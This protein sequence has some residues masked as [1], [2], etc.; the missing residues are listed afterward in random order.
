MT[1][2]LYAHTNNK[3]IKI[4]K[5]KKYHNKTPL[6]NLSY[7]L[8]STLLLP[9][10]CKVIKIKFK[11]AHHISSYSMRKIVKFGGLVTA[12]H[13]SFNTNSHKPDS[14]HYYIFLLFR[15]RPVSLEESNLLKVLATEV[16]ELR[17]NYT[18]NQKFSFYFK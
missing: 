15:Y 3:K 14:F 1:Q 12:K 5:I 4:K 10:P 9:V 7:F 17:K 2:A 8:K 18:Y 6:Y 13:A 11:L 16:Y